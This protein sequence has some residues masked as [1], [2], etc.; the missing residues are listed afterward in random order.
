M[1]VAV[2]T[3]SSRGLGREIAVTLAKCGYTVVINYCY[4]KG[5]AAETVQ[6]TDG[7]A[8]AVKA[9]VKLFRQ[10]KSM[11]DRVD[12][13]L[14]RVDALINN[15]GITRDSLLVQYPERDFDEVLSVNLKGCFNATRAFAPLMIRSGGGHIVNLSS[16]SGTRGK[17]GQ[18]AYSAA[19][20]GILGFTYS[21]AR[22]L[23]VHNIRVNAILPG[24]LPTE[25]GRSRE[26][27]LKRAQEESVLRRLSEP[28][29]VARFVAYLLTTKNIT[30]QVF[31]LDSRI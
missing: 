2:V 31:S 6:R 23:S 19:K 25:M 30:G 4:S 16:H 24:Y 22:E 7:K 29:E 18:V 10:V 14:G 13:K 12:R 5:E 11:A 21:A 26:R 8:M 20:A 9:D 1:P 28:G 17:A 3:G 15:A 27:A